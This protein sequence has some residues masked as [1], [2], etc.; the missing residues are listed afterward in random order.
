[1]AKLKIITTE[2]G[3]HSL[4]HEDLKETYHSFHGALRESQYVFIDKGLRYFRTKEGL[5]SEINVFEIGFG[6]GLNALLS[7]QFAESHEVKMHY[8]SLEPFPLEASIYGQLNYAAET[9]AENAQEVFSKLHEA[10]WNTATAISKHFTLLK[11]DTTLQEKDLSSVETIDVVFFDAFAPSKQAEIWDIA[12]I[13]K[14]YNCLRPSGVFVT[15][16]AKGQLKRDLRSVGFE[17]ETIPGPPG[18]KEMVRAIKI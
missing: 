18:K 11:E 12:L 4:Y 14:C 10:K 17:V 2:D 6:T 9:A 16:S 3:S 13:E 7:Q 1:M 8:R 5:P 15:Y